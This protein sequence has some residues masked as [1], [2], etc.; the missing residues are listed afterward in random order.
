MLYIILILGFIALGLLIGR[1][2][3]APYFLST[4]SYLMAIVVAAVWIIEHH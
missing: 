4:I 1:I 3:D 2:P